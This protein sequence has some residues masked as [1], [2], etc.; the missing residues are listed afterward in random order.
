MRNTLKTLIGL[1][2]MIAMTGC[3]ERTDCPCGYVPNGFLGE[4]CTWEFFYIDE[5]PQCK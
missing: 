5:R 3:A 4:Y 1:L 2:A